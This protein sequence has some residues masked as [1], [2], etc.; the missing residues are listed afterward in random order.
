MTTLIKAGAHKFFQD[1]SL[2]MPLGEIE[3]PNMFDFFNQIM[4]LD[5]RYKKSTAGQ[6]LNG[7]TKDK[8]VQIFQ[9]VPVLLSNENYKPAAKKLHIGKLLFEANGHGDYSKAR[10]AIE[11]VILNSQSVPVRFSTLT[12]PSMRTYQVGT[13]Y[14]V[15]GLTGHADKGFLIELNYHRVNH[16]SKNRPDVNFGT[17]SPMLETHS[18][19]FGR[20]KSTSHVLIKG[21][22]HPFV[23]DALVDNASRHLETTRIARHTIYRSPFGFYEKG[24]RHATPGVV[25]FVDAETINSEIKRRATLKYDTMLDIVVGEHLPTDSYWKRYAQ[26]FIDIKD[27]AKSKRFYSFNRVNSPPIPATQEGAEGLLKTL[28]VAALDAGYDPRIAKGEEFRKYLT[29]FLTEGEISTNFFLKSARGARLLK[30]IP[31]GLGLAAA[32]TYMYLSGRKQEQ[33]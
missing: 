17:L 8:K 10:N 1:I 21:E 4:P 5:A 20:I 33:A 15:S 28:Q 24:F 9:N 23:L 32:A 11:T 16:Y 31:I 25:N 26:K 30:A 2:R 18:I 14:N 7:A 3:T 29:R 12:A 19:E 6:I 13:G 27:S 22:Q